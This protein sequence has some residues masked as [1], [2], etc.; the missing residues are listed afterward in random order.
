MK[1]KNSPLVTVLLPA[2]NAEKFIIPAIESI[3]DQTY[4]NFEFIIIDDGSKDST[5]EIIQKYAKK[6]RRVKAIKNEVNLKIV[7]S[8]NKGLEVSKGKYIVRMDADDWSYPNRI[9]KQV[10]FMESNPEISVSGGAALVCNEKMQPIGIRH[11]PIN[12]QEM[13]NGILRLNPIPHPASIWRRD[14]LFKKTNLYPNV[15]AAEDYALIVEL[16]SFSKLGNMEDVLI[17]FRVH[18][19]SASNSTMILQQKTSMFIQD[20][21]V[22]IYGYRPTTKD[23][24]W[25]LIQKISMY[26]LPPKFKRWLLN[27]LVLDK[28]LSKI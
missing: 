13:R 16:S 18:T 10:Y 23:K 3:L 5:W 27:Q 28:D 8:L 12:D 7:K 26:T 22:F 9:E 24:I 1:Q 19:K 25:R 6:D 14:I 11:Y 21:A 15:I 2:Y 4:K 17:K 20:M